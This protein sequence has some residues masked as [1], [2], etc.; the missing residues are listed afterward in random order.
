[1]GSPKAA[2][3]SVAGLLALV[4]GLLL[5]PA[6]ASPAPAP[7]PAPRAPGLQLAGLL[8]ALFS[9]DPC[10]AK[11]A[12]P[13]GGLWTCTMADHFSGR[14]L[15]AQRWTPVT[16]AGEADLC[17]LNSPRTI[18]LAS[19]KLRLSAIKTDATARCPL[20]ADGTRATY[21]GGWVSSHYR[22][23]QQYGRFEARIKVAAAR[24]PGLHEAFWLW[25]DVRYGADSPW[26]ASGEIDIMETF[27][28]HPTIAIPYLHYGADDNGGP[29]PGLNTA[30]TCKAPRGS[31][32]TYVLEWTATQLTIKVDGRVCL[33]NTAGASSF[34]KPFII[35][36]TQFLG[37]A[38][39]PFTGTVRLP[40]T[41]EV[42]YVKVWR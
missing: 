29:V 13:G 31:W 27:S 19:G 6:S 2:V 35:N 10:G 22:F 42:D 34:R 20:R 37:G 3:A 30:W 21:A 17:M 40:A 32:H 1:M 14:V 41:M 39:N 16:P 28:A 24:V 18:A 26:P 9:S 12:R 15:D 38:G 11:L 7:T 5:A 4:L 8:G 36:F 33:V 25:P 23:G